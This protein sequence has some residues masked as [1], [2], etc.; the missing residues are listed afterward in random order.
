MSM[1]TSISYGYGIDSDG[2]D[3]ISDD[4][5]AKFAKKYL[6]RKYWNMDPSFLSTKEIIARISDFTDE[7]TQT[8][9]KYSVI[10]TVITA[11]TGIEFCYEETE[12]GKAVIFYAGYPW[13]M[14]AKERKLTT[15]WSMDKLLSPYLNELGISEIKPD[16]VS[17]ERLS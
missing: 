3:R 10:S 14:S 6:S 7:R 8:E 16:Y 9:S 5:L 12:F 2:L 13:N 17:V 1:K 4:C 11:E 15:E